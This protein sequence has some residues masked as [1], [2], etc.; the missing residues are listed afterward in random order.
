[1]CTLFPWP[2]V[3]F[4]ILRPPFLS[5][6][7]DFTLVPLT[8]QGQLVD[9]VDGAKAADVTSKVEKLAKDAAAAGPAPT[10]THEHVHS[11]AGIEVGISLAFTL[12]VDDMN[13]LCFRAYKMHTYSQIPCLSLQFLL[14]MHTGY[15]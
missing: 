8:Q 4:L 5:R 6:H 11:H 1:M 13:L 12:R 2:R 10:H 3:L 9:R 7:S 15:Q 14:H